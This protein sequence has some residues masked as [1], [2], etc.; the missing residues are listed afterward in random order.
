MLSF[1][2]KMKMSE[3]G[4]LFIVPTPVGNLEDMTFRAVKI[5]QQV[6]LIAAEDTRKSG[7]LLKYYSI[8]TPMASYHKFNERSRVADF[9]SKLEAGKNIAVISDAGTPGIADPAQIIIKEVIKAGI[10]VETLPGATA[11]VPA[12]VNSGLECSRF[13]FAGFTSDK[14]RK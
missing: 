5:L 10:A 14:P 4:K 9:L 11:F 7:I 8:T 1:K 2:A 12:I 6:D 13:H 3:K